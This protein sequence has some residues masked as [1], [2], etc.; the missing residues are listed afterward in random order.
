M[1]IGKVPLNFIRALPSTTLC[2]VLEYA[3]ETW[4][5]LLAAYPAAHRLTQDEPALS[6]SLSE[7]LNDDERKRNKG[8]NGEFIAEAFELLRKPDGTVIQH[9]RADIKFILGTAGAPVIVIE[10][11]KLNGDAISRRLYCAKGIMRFI[12]GKYAK[13]D[14]VGVMCGFACASSV[15]RIELAAYIADG[16]QS[17]SLHCI[18]PPGGKLI[19]EPSV[20][21]PNAACFDTIHGR[22]GLSHRKPITLAHM[23]LDCPP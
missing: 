8:I 15:E 2:Q 20:C 11:K 18:V 7:A 4:N 1:M 14:S 17:S 21:A 5:W 23:I 12:E 16:T 22:P 6:M 19:T 3:V 9:G 10:C 13:L